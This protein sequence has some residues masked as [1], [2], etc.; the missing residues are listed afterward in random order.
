MASKIIHTCID[1]RGA[2]LNWSD[3]IMRGV[4]TDDA[5]KVMSVREAKLF[6]LEQIA[7]GRKVIPCSGDCD[8]FDYQKGCPGHDVTEPASDVEIR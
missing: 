3:R 5:G 7:M 8:G 4:F 6:L 1:L 2:L